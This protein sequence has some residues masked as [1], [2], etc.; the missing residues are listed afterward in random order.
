[1]VGVSAP[2]CVRH[3]KRTANVTHSRSRRKSTK[4][5]YLCN[6]ILS[7]FSLYVVDYLFTSVKAKI[8]IEIGHRNSLGIQKALEEQIKFKRVNV[9]DFNAVSHKASRTRAT[10]GT[11]GN[12][13]AL[14]VAYKISNHKEVGI[15][16]HFIYN[17][18]LVLN[19]R[20]IF[21]LRMLVKAD[22]GAELSLFKA[23]ISIA[24]KLVLMR[25]S[26]GGFKIRKMKLVKFKVKIAL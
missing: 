3:T 8:Y 2:A 22:S 6:L 19:S 10:S 4:G 13:L 16:A 21:R 17:V 18:K 11:D 7:V 23:E 14:G 20:N 26:V 5:H 24:A 9:C 12:P 1:M 25:K 15:K